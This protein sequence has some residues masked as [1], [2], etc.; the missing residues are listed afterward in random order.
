LSW[1]N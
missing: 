1:W